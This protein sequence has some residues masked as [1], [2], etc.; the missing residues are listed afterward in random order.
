MC[1]SVAFNYCIVAKNPWFHTAWAICYT[2]SL[3][4]SGPWWIVESHYKMI[5]LK[6][7]G[8]SSDKLVWRSYFWTMIAL[9]KK[10]EREKGR[11]GETLFVVLCNYVQFR[12]KG[13]DT[14]FTVRDPFKGLGEGFA[15]HLEMNCLRETHVLTK[16]ETLLKREHSRGEQQG[17]GTRRTP[18]SHAS[19]S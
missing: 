15:Q 13:Q 2:L 14:S 8:T 3:F 10:G 19:Q 11:K 5:L 6:E 18:L 17:K 12:G 1:K 4:F 7:E 16:Q 9:T